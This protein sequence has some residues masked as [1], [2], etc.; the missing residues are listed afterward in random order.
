MSSFN[1]L[2]RDIKKYI[3]E[4]GWTYL[5]KIQEASIKRLNETEDNL[6]LVAPT[7]SGKTEAAFLPTINAVKNWKKGVKI[8]YI[9]PMIAL[10]NDQFKRICKLCEYMD[11][12]VTMWHG[13]A[14][15]AEKNNLL[16][17]PS[18]IVLITP[19]SIEAMLS[20]R[21]NEAKSMFSSV[22]YVIIDEIHNFLDN[23]RGLQLRSLIE[24]VEKYIKNDPRFI[25]MSATLNK[26]DYVK[27]K[28]F[29]KTSRNTVV[30]LDKTKNDLEITTSFNEN[31]YINEIYDYSQEETMLVFPNSRKIVEE[32][33]VELNKLALKNGTKV[34]YFAHHSSIS[35]EMRKKVEQFAKFNESQLF[36]ICCTSTLE[37]GIDI[38]SVDSV[39]QYNAPY[40]VASLAQRV[41][42]SG[43]KN[44][45]SIL[46]FIATDEWELLQGLATILLYKEDKIDKFDPIIKPYDV[47]AHQVISILCETNGIP[48]NK[49][50]HLNKEFKCFNDIKDDEYMNLISY[51]IEKEYIEVLDN[52]EVIVGM[53]SEKLIKSREFFSHFKTEKNFTV[54]NNQKKIGEI[55]N[56]INLQVGTNIYLAAKIWKILDIDIKLKKV[57]VIEAFDGKAPKFSGGVM[58]VTMEVRSKMKEI[59]VN[60]E[61]WGEYDDK[62]KNILENLLFE[63]KHETEGIR[64]F[65]SS[66]VNATIYLLLK[67]LNPNKSYILRENKTLISGEDIK[68]DLIALRERKFTRDDIIIYL[69]NNQKMVDIYLVNNVYAMLLPNN[70]KID[71]VINNKLD[72]NGTNEY[73]DCI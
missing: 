37:L 63:L 71:Y 11:I 16:K 3:Y 8:V 61:L 50:K 1:L 25:G 23:N 39:V 22:E 42:R 52:G 29:F 12:Q 21:Q 2:N 5:T 65:Q 24:R 15:R 64:T 27:V 45:K 72:I 51:L 4:K 26:E 66:K 57:F 36:T 55:P 59:L 32:L 68:E 44:K 17:D 35:K 14:S 6:I 13:E 34:K 69:K 31:G 10:I 70:L 54:Y 48:L 62:I 38:G 40:S 7:A 49:L 30:L 9:S 19:E 73:L 58:N 28:D 53:S 18:G 43:R 47:L 33:S 20:Y 67:M 56:D 41:G 60:R 46:H